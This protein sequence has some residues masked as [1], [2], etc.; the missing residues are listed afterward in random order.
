MTQTASLS[1]DTL[2]DSTKILTLTGHCDLSAARQAEQRIDSAID[3]GA[4]DVIVDLRGVTS[5]DRPMLQV[6][7]RALIRMGHGSRLALVRPGAKVWE[8]FEEAGLDRGFS[9][10]A[11]LKAALA[12]VSNR[13][14]QG[15]LRPGQFHTAPFR[16]L[17]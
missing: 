17:R 7:F 12:S 1:P 8:R 4:T 6:L 9:T 15:P 2:V 11:D 3:G 13:G 14:S 16:G 5:V 10:F